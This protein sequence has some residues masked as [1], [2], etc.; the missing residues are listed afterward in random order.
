MLLKV[1]MEGKYRILV[2]DDERL[3]CWSLTKALEK[4][5]C[6]V[7]S[8]QTGEE[9]LQRNREMNFDVVITDLRLPGIDGIDLLKEI[10]QTT[11]NCRVIIISAYGT[12]QIAVE[13]KEEGAFDFIDKPLVMDDVRKVVR[14]S[15]EH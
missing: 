13:A 1:V 15:L 4:D 8:A 5:Y 7:V 10:R 3:I 6:E 2:V 9:A 11:P 14:A 12:P